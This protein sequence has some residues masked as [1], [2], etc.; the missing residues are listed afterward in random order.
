MPTDGQTKHF[1]YSFIS[2]KDG[3]ESCEKWLHGFVHYG[4]AVEEIFVFYKCLESSQCPSVSYGF[5][6]AFLFLGITSYF[7][8]YKMF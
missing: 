3:Y 1:H 2:G 8:R 7:L 5:F 6:K 4:L